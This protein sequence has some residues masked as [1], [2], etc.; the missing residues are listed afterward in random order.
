MGVLAG[1]LGHGRPFSFSLLPPRPPCFGLRR[2]LIGSAHTRRDGS[3]GGGGGDDDDESD[4]DIHGQAA[5]LVLHRRAAEI[6]LP[7]LA[8]CQHFVNLTNGLEAVPLL[9]Q[10]GLPFSYMRLESTQ[11]EQKNYDQVLASLDPNLLMHLALGYSCIIWDFGSRNRRR[12]VPRAIWFGIEF[13]RFALA[14]EWYGVGYRKGSVSDQ[15]L[16]DIDHQERDARNINLADPH[17]VLNASSSS[18]SS[19]G[20]HGF[21]RPPPILRGYDV[22]VDFEQAMRSTKKSSRKRLKY[23]RRFLAPRQIP[24]RT[25]S[26]SE[27]DYQGDPLIRL[28]GAY[29]ATFE[30]E[31]LAFYQQIAA[32]VSSREVQD[33]MWPVATSL[34]ADLESLGMK[35]WTGGVGHREYY[36]ALERL[37]EEDT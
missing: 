19:S 3:D 17:P 1:A 37:R 8:Q 30:D 21:P 31:Q 14:R 5:R 24:D 27:G 28:Y 25:L 22:A 23:Y 4:D 20:S 2:V 7:P 26:S 16:A 9:T 18:S 32:E 13:V 10:R 34:V 6:R 36:D 11:L 29:R 33:D 12:G 15:N 35:L